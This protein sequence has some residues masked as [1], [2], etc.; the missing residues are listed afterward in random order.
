MSSNGEQE[1]EWQ[2][3]S[4]HYIAIYTAVMVNSAYDTIHSPAQWTVDIPGWY[5]SCYF[6]LA[7]LASDGSFANIPYS[8]KFSHGANFCIFRMK[9]SVCENK[10]CKIYANASTRTY[11]STCGLNWGAWRCACACVHA[12]K[13]NAKFNS[14]AISWFLRKFAPSKI[15]RYTVSYRK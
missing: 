14:K 13:K 15:S 9:A 10:K 12:E 8:G 2:L 6:N 5:Y 4:I 11:V 7:N 1:T 3:Q